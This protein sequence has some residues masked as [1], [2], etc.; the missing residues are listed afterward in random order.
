[1][2]EKI[3]VFPVI[4]F[5]VFVVVSLVVMLCIQEQNRQSHNS[6]VGGIVCGIL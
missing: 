4:V 3:G 2:K 5:F 6:R 1:M